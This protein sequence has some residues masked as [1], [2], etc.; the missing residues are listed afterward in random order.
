MNR[1]YLMIAGAILCISVACQPKKQ[2]QRHMMPREEQQEEQKSPS[3]QKKEK[4][5]SCDEDTCFIEEEVILEEKQMEAFELSQMIDVESEQPAVAAIEETHI[6]MILPEV[7]L[8]PLTE[9]PEAPSDKEV[10]ISTPEET[11]PNS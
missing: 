10:V 5:P 2:E 4:I 11:S 6:E 9:T 7:E 3:P 1:N 8:P